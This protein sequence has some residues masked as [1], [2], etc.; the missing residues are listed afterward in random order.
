[1]GLVSSFLLK[2]AKF[3]LL[4][5]ALLFAVFLRFNSVSAFRSVS[6]I[7]SS[8]SCSRL[9]E[10]SL[11]QGSEDLAV[12]EASGRVII[13]SMSF[14]NVMSSSSFSNANGGLFSLD[15]GQRQLS[16][17]EL[18][19]VSDNSAFAPHG[20]DIVGNTMFVVA[21]QDRGDCIRV[22]RLHDDVATQEREICSPLFVSPNTVAG[23][24]DGS[25]FVVNDHSRSQV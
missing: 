6:D 3:S 17:L 23:R 13:S 25:F 15:V 18:R 7:P 9:F 4:L 8:W 20:I 5:A 1:M 12:H 14:V 2:F 24:A 16:R 21:H 11:G 10:D 22:F 19:N